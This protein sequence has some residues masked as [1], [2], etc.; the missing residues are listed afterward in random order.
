V[1]T[2]LTSNQQKLLGWLAAGTACT[3]D[4]LAARWPER[5]REGIS[6]TAASL[7]DLGLAVRLADG[8]AIANGSG[9]ANGDRQF[10]RELGAGLRALRTGRGL[11]LEQVHTASG[12]RWKATTLRSWEAG[13]RAIRAEDLDGLARFYRVPVAD[14]IPDPVR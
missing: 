1:S 14:L 4:E 7:V 9:M 3:H 13:T 12:H 5:T 10:A 8:W 2:K 6:E 11:S